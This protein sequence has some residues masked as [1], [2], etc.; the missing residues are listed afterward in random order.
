VQP[1][2]L[3]LYFHQCEKLKSNKILD[4]FASK[5][6]IIMLELNQNR[7]SGLAI[8]GVMKVLQT[9]QN[10]TLCHIHKLLQ[11]LQSKPNVTPH[12]NK[13]F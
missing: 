11:T 10:Q 5:D 2:R 4:Y 7:M 12:K 8:N 13:H 6:I 3:Q 9:F 1:V